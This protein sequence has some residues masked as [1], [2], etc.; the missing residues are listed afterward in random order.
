MELRILR[1]FLAVIEE[2]SISNA[3]KALHLTQ[4]TLSRQL[5]SLEDEMGRQLYTR[6]HNGIQLTE[7]GIILQRHAESI[8][9]LAEKA[10]EDMK[11][12][13]SSVSGPVHI[14]AGETKLMGLLAQAMMRVRKEHPGVTFEIYCG[15]SADLKDD[16][17]RS[18]C[19]ILLECE[20]Q[21]HP[22]FNVMRLPITDRWGVLTRADS[23]LANK[24]GVTRE[25]LL[26]HPIITSRQGKKTILNQWLGDTADRLNI[27]ATYNLPLNGKFLV[28]QG[29]GDMLTYEELFTSSKDNGLVFVPLE[30]ELRSVQGIVWRKTLPTKQTQVFI[31]TLKEICREYELQ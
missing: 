20:L 1:Y 21:A 11:L 3:A 27:V 10:E 9:A 26:G 6:T 8:V 7:A 15:T 19:D 16:L 30:P 31:D 29:F 2:G 23:D 13:G 12:P 17:V 5:A 22:K 4:P 14:G 28:Q 24:A 25:D 18:F